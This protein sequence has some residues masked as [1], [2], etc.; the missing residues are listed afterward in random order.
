MRFL[1]Y[2]GHWLPILELVFLL[3]LV[4]IGF[5]FVLGVFDPSSPD[6][7]RV[8]YRERFFS[9]YTGSHA[10]LEQQI[11]KSLSA[12][13][14]YQHVRT[15]WVERGAILQVTT[16]FWCRQGSGLLGLDSA[17]ATLDTTNGHILKWRMM[18]HRKAKAELDQQKKP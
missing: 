18:K 13:A 12:P 16:V 7:Q 8:S 11:K 3:A 6:T 9:P 15:S 2:N 14:S 1:R 10:A 17:Q 4:I 5:L